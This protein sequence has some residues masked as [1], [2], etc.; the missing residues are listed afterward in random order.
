[1]LFL[2]GCVTVIAIGWLLSA[3]AGFRAQRPDDY[4]D[5]PVFDLREHFDGP[6]ICDGVI[7]GPFGRVTSRF[8]AQMMGEWSG[9]TGVLRERFTYE[10][11]MVQDREWRM[12]ITDDGRIKAEAD[13]LQGAGLGQQRGNA[14][15]LKYRIVLPKDAGGHA[16]D[17]V[18]WMYRLNGGVVMNRSQFRKFGI[19]VA[20]LVATVRPATTEEAMEIEAAA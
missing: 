9:N 8:T 10:S 17:V 16:L 18:D 11:G 12:V 2:L 7:Y 1:M 13:D 19:K 14:V 6:L 20:E 15:Q 4:A 3:F 5:G